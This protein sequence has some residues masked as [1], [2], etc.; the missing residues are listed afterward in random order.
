VQRSFLNKSSITTVMTAETPTGGKNAMNNNFMKL[1]RRSL[2]HY[3]FWI[4]FFYFV[5]SM[6][7]LS[8]PF[9]NILY[10]QIVWLFML[11][12]PLWFRPL[13][14]FLNNTTLL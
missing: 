2:D 6:Y 8:A 11:C 7:N 12:L 10:I 4:T 13:A 3:T 14:R 9:T 5:I 1:F